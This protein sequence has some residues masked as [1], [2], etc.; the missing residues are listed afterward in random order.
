MSR[1]PFVNERGRVVIF[2]TPSGIKFTLTLDNKD[3]LSIGSLY[4]DQRIPLCNS[5]YALDKESAMLLS[6]EIDRI[7]HD[8]DSDYSA[9]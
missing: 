1:S 9:S 4:K 2:D 8:T 7:Y 3:G 6:K 5:S